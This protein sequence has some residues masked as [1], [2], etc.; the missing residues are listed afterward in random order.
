MT[1][2]EH[3]PKRVA[4]AMTWQEPQQ[5]VG[6]MR[7][8]RHAGWSIRQ[9][10]P[11]DYAEVADWKPDGIIAQLYHNNPDMVNVVRAAAVP[12][13]ELH[14]YIPGMDVPRVMADI[15][16]AG[17]LA[18]GH[19]LACHFGRLIHAGML[20]SSGRSSHTLSG[21]ESRAAEAGV[22]VQRIDFTDASF[23]AERGVHTEGGLSWELCRR[24]AA[25]LARW[26]VEDPEPAAI[27]CEEPQFALDMVDAAMDMGL[28]IPEQL[29]V[30][31]LATQP[32]ENELA[33]IP[34]SC[35]RSD[36]ETQGYLAAQTLDRMMHGETVPTLQWVPP[37]PVEPRESTDTIATRFL[38][39][40]LAMKHFRQNALDYTFTPNRAAEELGVSL[41][42]LHRWFKTYAGRTPAAMIEQR[43]AHHAMHLLQH[44]RIAPEEAAARSGFS[45]L[46]QLRRALKRQ[47]GVEP[48]TI[49]NLVLTPPAVPGHR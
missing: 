9:K 44:E 6:V 14:A 30:L 4:V 11:L 21:F 18:A 23:W 3:K 48:R 45:G 33:R 22:P 8:A 20:R 26:I 47:L 35:I 29:A 25:A 38:P 37:L 42:T 13:V 31:M 28:L 49:R 34:V 32:H 41:P 5:M 1:R 46:Q 24:G 15:N 39:A 19:F 2:W 16:A 10:G 27:F 7:Y 36:F 12:T 43:R 17:S 40:A